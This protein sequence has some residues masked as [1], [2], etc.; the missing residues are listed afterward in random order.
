MRVVVCVCEDGYKGGGDFGGGAGG[1]VAEG[2]GEG[3][4]DEFVGLGGCGSSGGEVILVDLVNGRVQQL[5][6]TSSEK[7]NNI[8]NKSNSPPNIHRD[9]FSMNKRYTHSCNWVTSTPPSSSVC[10]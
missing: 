2:V 9:I 1:Y 3:G 4:F 6:N 10:R 7:S 8:P 5:L